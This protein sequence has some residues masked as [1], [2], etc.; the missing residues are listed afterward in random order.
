[1][2]V[3]V[4]NTKSSLLPNLPQS[5]LKVPL[6]S[7]NKDDASKFISEASSVDENPK[8]FN[9]RL[10]RSLEV[11]VSFTIHDVQAPIVKIKIKFES[12]VFTT[13]TNEEKSL[14][15]SCFLQSCNDNA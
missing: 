11:I 14:N 2:S 7:S 8:P 5:I 4:V 12:A 3:S 15:L 1:M 9:P 10:Y 6:N 13:Q